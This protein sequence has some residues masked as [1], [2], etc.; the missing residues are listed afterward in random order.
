MRPCGTGVLDWLVSE[1]QAS[2]N[3]SLPD[4]MTT[5][6]KTCDPEVTFESWGIKF[7]REYEMV[8]QDYYLNRDRAAALSNALKEVLSIPSL[9]AVKLCLDERTVTIIPIV[10]PVEITL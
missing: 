10:K 3:R 5:G 4:Q 2:R 7:E 1:V 9:D 6:T 8:S